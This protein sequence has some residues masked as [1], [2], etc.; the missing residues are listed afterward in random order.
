MSASR[1]HMV[2]AHDSHGCVLQFVPHCLTKADS[3]VLSGGD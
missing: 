2:N 1:G 3:V